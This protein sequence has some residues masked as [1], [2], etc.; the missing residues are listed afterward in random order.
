MFNTSNIQ[1]SCLSWGCVS[2]LPNELRTKTAGP[3]VIRVRVRLV[4]NQTA[5]LRWG[6]KPALF[7]RTYTFF[8]KTPGHTAVSGQA[9]VRARARAR[10]GPGPG[11][12]Q[13][14]PTRNLR[15]VRLR[16][17]QA[18]LTPS[19]HRIHKGGAARCAPAQRAAWRGVSAAASGEWR[20]VLHDTWWCSVCQADARHWSIIEIIGVGI[21][22]SNSRLR[23][24]RSAASRWLHRPQ[25]RPIPRSA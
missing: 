18:R 12:G 21:D 6:Q 24:A 5:G 19:A 7:Q 23:A 14:E 22:T 15:R 16:G 10:P 8:T 25:Q 11:Q 4:M 9:R 20:Q 3:G 17:G 1:Y 2:L 13:P